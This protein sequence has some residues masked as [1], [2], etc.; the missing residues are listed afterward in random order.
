MSIRVSVIICTLN[1]AACLQK[2]IQSL[3]DQTLPKEQYEIIVVDN[4]S[5]DNT[6]ATVEGFK[7]FEN[8]RY[9]YEP[10]LGLSQARNTGWQNA[11]GEYVAYIDDDAIACPKWLESIVTAFETVK[12]QP[13]S[14]GGKVIPVWEAERPAWLPKEMENAF[15]IVDRGDKPRFL[16]EE[17]EHHVG[18]NVVYQ[19]E[20]LQECGGFNTNLGRKGTNLL[21]NDE[22]LIRSYIRQHNLG[23]YYNPEICVEH[24]IPAERL[25]KRFF[26][27]R[28]FWQ[29]I[30]D[31]ILNYLESRQRK[32]KWR[33]VH[34]AI[35]NTLS[36]VRQPIVLLWLLIRP[37]NRAS[38]FETKCGLCWWLGSIWGKLQIGFGRIR[39]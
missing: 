9:I 1:H 17:H 35:V 24:L 30:S 26:Y 7:R 8:L 4:G 25:V 39:E 32:S 22:N 38:W 28:A 36:F 37:A 21:S 19:R 6:K 15:A 23:I 18:C 29:G 12:P 2:A 31:E 33:Y 27:R 10:V 34:R 20:I 5:T 14:V 13:G 3:V 16:T 11:E